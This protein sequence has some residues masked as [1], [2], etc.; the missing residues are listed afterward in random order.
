MHQHLTNMAQQAKEVMQYAQVA[1]SNFRVGACI[2][3]TNNKFFTGCNIEDITFSLTTHAE[4][5]AI[6]NMI[7]HGEKEI[8]DIVIIAANID[9]CPPCGICRQRIAAF[10]N[11]KTKIH[12]CNRQGEITKSFAVAELLPET[13]VREGF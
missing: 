9:N 5:A 4:E 2:R 1:F 10:A 3:T 7:I 13:F 12:L 8:A 6:T 11:A